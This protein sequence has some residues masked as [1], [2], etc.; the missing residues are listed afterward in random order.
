MRGA[1]GGVWRRGGLGDGGGGR[2]LA[3]EWAV[4][5][6]R[7]L[8]EGLGCIVGEE[9]EVAVAGI[10]EVQVGGIVAVV[11]SGTEEVVEELDGIG[12][13]EEL[14]DTE[15]VGLLRPGVGVRAVGETGVSVPKEDIVRSDSERVTTRPPGPPPGAPKFALPPT[16]P[17]IRNGEELVQEL[18][19]L[20]LTVDDNTH[21]ATAAFATY[22]TLSSRDDELLA[23]GSK[24]LGMA[25][26]ENMGYQEDVYDEVYDSIAP[27]AQI[28]NQPHIDPSTLHVHAVD[29]QSPHL[30][31]RH[32]IG[33]ASASIDLSQLVDIVQNLQA[34]QL[35]EVQAALKGKYVTTLF[36]PGDCRDV[37][38]IASMSGSAWDC[39]KGRVAF[40]KMTYPP[41][42]SCLMDGD[43]E[44]VAFLKVTWPMSPSIASPQTQGYVAFLKMTYPLSPSGLMDGDM[45]PCGG[46]DEQSYGV[47]DR[48]YFP[49]HVSFSFVSALPFVGESSQQRQ[50]ARRAEETGR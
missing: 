29:S 22:P 13:E 3:Y 12:W 2:G 23:K 28:H 25:E 8:E 26:Y 16:D 15:V 32:A 30:S 6:W 27:L 7:C 44:Y 43:M 5:L 37:V 34:S 42:P 24:S 31:P 20:T 4:G 10:E 38:P 40:V 36:I 33:N 48:E 35:Q 1:V 46:H 41:S 47:S 39:D 11:L 9:E 45:G 49:Y 21:G 14:V 18:T 50:G 19:T 17:K